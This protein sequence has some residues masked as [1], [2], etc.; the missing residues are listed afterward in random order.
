MNPPPAALVHARRLVAWT[1]QVH[2]M[3]DQLH[4][5]DVNSTGFHRLAARKMA[6]DA[7]ASFTDVANYEEEP[8]VL[9]FRAEE[10]EESAS[11]A[12]RILAAYLKE[13]RTKETPTGFAHA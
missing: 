2:A 7:W 5:Q 8:E 1:Y 13:R 3:L 9:E 6:E 10:I 4:R 11:S 12:E